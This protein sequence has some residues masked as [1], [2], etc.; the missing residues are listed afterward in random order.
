MIFLVFQKFAGRIFGVSTA[1]IRDGLPG[2]RERGGFQL[3]HCY[4]MIILNFRKCIAVG[5]ASG[6][7]IHPV[8]RSAASWSCQ[9]VLPTN[10]V[11]SGNIRN[12]TESKWCVNFTPDQVF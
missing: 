9:S 10:A 6:I 8:C 4:K 12:I 5:W 2:T 1:K 7:F 3:V 11:A